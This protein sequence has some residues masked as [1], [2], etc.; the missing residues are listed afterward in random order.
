[1]IDL[2][3]IELE[4]MFADLDKEAEEEH[5]K[6]VHDQGWSFKGFRQYIELQIGTKESTEDDWVELFNYYGWCLC[7]TKINTIDEF[8][9]YQIK[10]KTS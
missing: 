5:I 7:L 2:K 8:I 1:M 6:A 4:E 9:E 10:N 3:Q